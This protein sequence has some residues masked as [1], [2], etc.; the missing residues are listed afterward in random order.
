MAELRPINTIKL[1]P[2]K[3]GSYASMLKSTLISGEEILAEYTSTIGSSSTGFVV[4][5]NKRIILGEIGAI[6]KKIISS[7]PYSRTITF[8][9][10]TGIAKFNYD[11]RL[12]MYTY[13]ASGIPY[14]FLF[15]DSIKAETIEKI[16][17]VISEK[18]L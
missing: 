12:D 14:T 18:I 5:T 1:S 9:I 8:S 2:S 7:I 13:D 11:T 4:F 10:A 3:E 16:G 17:R 6:R 15:H